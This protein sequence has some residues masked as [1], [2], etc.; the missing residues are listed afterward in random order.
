VHQITQPG[1]ERDRPGEG[2]QRGSRQRRVDGEAAAHRTQPV[3]SNLK[4]VRGM[5]I[6]D[7][8]AFDF[9]WNSCVV[10]FGRC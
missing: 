9:Y 1:R 6:G 2:Q 3:W 4:Y 5:R 8:Y 7:N 10:D